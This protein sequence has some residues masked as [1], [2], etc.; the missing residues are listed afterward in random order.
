M[1]RPTNS[2]TLKSRPILIAVALVILV[3]GAYAGV[4]RNEF[5]AYDDPDYV[6]N[7]PPVRAGLTGDTV[8]WALTTGHTANW[9]PLTWLS[10]ML[11][12]RAVRPRRRAG[13]T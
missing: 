5:I 13:I 4:A 8:A 3:A 11:D 7:N 12:C 1:G 6:T 2:T 10:H 9:H